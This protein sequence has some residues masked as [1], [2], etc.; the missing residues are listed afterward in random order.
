MSFIEPSDIKRQQRNEENTKLK[1]ITPILQERWGKDH[2]IL[3]EYGFT[4]GRIQVFDD[5][6]VRREDAK[7]A[8]Y[9]LLYKNNRLLAVVEA[10]R[11]DLNAEEGYQQAIEY[12]EILDAPFAYS[13]NG[14][15]LIE[16]NRLTGKNK[17]MR[18]IDFPYPDDLW[19]QYIEHNDYKDRQ[20]TILEYP[21]YKDRSGKSPRYYQRNAINRTI[22]AILKG[23]KRILLVMATGTGKTY[24]AFQIIHRFWSTKEKK[25]ILFLADRNFLV[26]QTMKDDFAPFRDSMYKIESHKL[27]TEYEIYLSLYHQ[28]MLGDNRYFEEYPRDFF[29]MI[30][31]DECH[32]GSADEEGNWHEIL[33]YFGSAVQIGLTATPKQ[34]EDSS[35]LE[36]F[37]DPVY[38]Y[39]LKQGIEDGFLAPYKVLVP[40]LDIDKNGYRPKPRTVD[41]YGEPVEDRVY[42]QHEF[43]RKIIVQERREIVAQRVTDYLHESGN[44]FQKTIIFCE[45]IEHAG[46]M[47]RLLENLNSDLVKEDYRY[48]MRIVG[49]DKEGKDQ[50]ENFMDPTS[51]YPA[52]VTT[53][54]LLSTGANIQTCKMI[55]LDKTIGSMTE[56]KQ[57]IGRGTRVRESYSVDGKDYSKMYFTIMDFRSNYLKFQDPEFDGEPFDEPTT[58]TPKSGGSESTETTTPK[59]KIARV[60]GVDVEI[61]NE[62]V[63]YYGEDGRLVTENILSMAKK[64]VKFYFETPE[65]FQS[66]WFKL[67]D[68]SQLVEEVLLDYDFKERFLKE[69]GFVSSWFDIILYLGFD[70][71]L[72]SK[73]KRLRDS[74]LDSYIED[75]E[76]SQKREILEE[77]ARVY[78]DSSIS[79]LYNLRIYSRTNFTK[80][81]WSPLSITNLFGS[82]DNLINTVKHIEAIIYK[83]Y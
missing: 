70:I 24:T 69:F 28:L 36:Y 33:K 37:G 16:R 65:Q 56:F 67:N 38:T 78:L 71:P 68:K 30:V 53:S 20:K 62:F 25:K 34:T 22:E 51:K 40:E 55:V 63:Q 83:D 12:A 11:I 2:D 49:D 27:N 29:D 1:Y 18:M 3:M 73:E 82:R 72:I 42:E 57:I 45:S 15:D 35:N 39:S 54:K 76:S 23:Q 41:I 43:D 21:F 8:D 60:N 6:Q 61:I 9:I 74:S 32:R 79:E 7:K 19:D 47:K 4:D 46:E 80:L 44:R 50:L 52:I 64:N 26:D 17:S 81:G 58:T 10:K 75:I 14:V 66:E 59:K 5:G 31:I 77:M 13:T 48:V